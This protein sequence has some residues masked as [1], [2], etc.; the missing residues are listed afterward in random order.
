VTGCRRE[1]PSPRWHDPPHSRGLLTRAWL[2]FLEGDADGARADLDEAWD[3]AERGPMR[4]HMAD[5]HL[6][7]RPPLLPHETLPVAVPAGRPR[8]FR[9]THSTTAATHRRDEEL[10]DAKRVL[11]GFIG[12]PIRSSALVSNVISLGLLRRF[13]KSRRGKLDIQDKRR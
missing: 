7:P 2:R 5:I 3:I 6:H 1:R 4:L 13:S 11:L 8:R 12:L 10:A 9:E